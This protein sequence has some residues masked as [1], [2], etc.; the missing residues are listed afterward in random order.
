MGPIPNYTV[1]TRHS[2]A[3]MSSV[4][5][6]GVALTELSETIGQ[7]AKETQSYFVDFKKHGDTNDSMIQNKGLINL[8]HE[9]LGQNDTDET[10]LTIEMLQKHTGNY[11]LMNLKF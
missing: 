8:A 1:T 9:Y 5:R 2:L 6:D 10:T 11:S 7:G 4:S 3:W